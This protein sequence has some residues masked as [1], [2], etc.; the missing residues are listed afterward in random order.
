MSPVLPADRLA[1]RLIVAVTTA[2]WIGIIVCIATQS[3]K[4]VLGGDLPPWVTVATVLLGFGSML[5][6][7]MTS[8]VLAAHGKK[9][10][11]PKEVATLLYGFSFAGALLL[12]FLAR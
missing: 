2:A 7:F 11:S 5:L 1:T 12:G 8:I 10:C 6:T 3:G 4:G 9:T